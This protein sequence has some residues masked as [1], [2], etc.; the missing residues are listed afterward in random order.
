M[1]GLHLSGPDQAPVIKPTIEAMLEIDPAW[2]VPTHCTGRDAALKIEEAFS[3][4]FILNMAGTKLT[5][6]S[7]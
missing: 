7:D 4:R 2:I 3:D 6:A 5:F 1:G